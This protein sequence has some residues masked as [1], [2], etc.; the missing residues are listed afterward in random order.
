MLTNITNCTHFCNNSDL[1]RGNKKCDFLFA[2]VVLV[3]TFS[4]K[5]N[6][7]VN[8]YI[9]KISQIFFILI[10]KVYTYLPPAISSYNQQT[11]LLMLVKSLKSENPQLNT[12]QFYKLSFVK[13]SS[14]IIKKKIRKKKQTMI[15]KYETVRCFLS[16]GCYW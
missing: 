12:T 4:I 13:I 3:I 11:V 6:T 10:I 2:S 15:K 9:I 16:Y 1:S 8:H 7:F 14:D 5:C